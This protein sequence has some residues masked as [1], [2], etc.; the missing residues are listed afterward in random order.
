MQKRDLETYQK[1]F[2]DFKILLNFSRPTFLEVPF[3]TPVRGWVE[4]NKKKE[5]WGQCEGH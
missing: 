5:F 4:R 1:C 3:A 2:R